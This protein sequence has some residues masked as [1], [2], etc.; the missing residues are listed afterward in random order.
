M[1]KEPHLSPNQLIEEAKALLTQ[2]VKSQ[3]EG[4]LSLFESCFLHTEEL[5]NIG[6]DLDEI[7]YGWDDFSRFMKNAITERKGHK[8]QELDTRIVVDE[9][10]TT[11]W[12]SQ[13]IDTCI[14]TKSEPFRLEGFRHT[15]VMIFR[16]GQWRI[17]QSHISAPIIVNLEQDGM[18]ALE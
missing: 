8:I 15:G 10:G 4:D 12:Y 6:T 9:G 3:E 7:W 13:L 14:E 2:L 16:N 1:K 18:D 5:V 17:A 11:A